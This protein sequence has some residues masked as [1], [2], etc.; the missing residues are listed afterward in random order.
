M[1][2]SYLLIW[3]CE[4]KTLSTYQNVSWQF[5]P[6]SPPSWVFAAS[7]SNLDIMSGGPP[8]AI[9]ASGACCFF[10]AVTCI[11]HKYGQ[12]CI[13]LNMAEPWISVIFSPWILIWQSCMNP[14]CCNKHN[15]KYCLIS[16]SSTSSFMSYTNKGVK[17][18]NDCSLYP[19]VKLVCNNLLS[20]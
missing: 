12:M 5:C 20:L 19:S 15:L 7:F 9:S 2:F 13:Q 16:M 8:H 4:W 17:R 6:R 10:R 11:L 18:R 14:D 3:Q 1:Y